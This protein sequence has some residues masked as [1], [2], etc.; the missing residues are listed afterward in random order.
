MIGVFASQKLKKYPKNWIGRKD[1]IN[2]IFK[3]LHVN[4][5]RRPVNPVYVLST[6]YRLPFL[7]FSVASVFT[8]LLH[9]AG[10]EVFN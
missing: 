8:R 10:V 4:P 7:G 2:R 1:R 9:S 6:G 5:A 3:D